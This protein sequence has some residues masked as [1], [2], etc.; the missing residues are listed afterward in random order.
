TVE[1]QQAVEAETKGRP[2]GRIETLDGDVADER[3]KVKLE[4]A[5]P[6]ERPVDEAGRERG[7]ARRERGIGEPMREQDVGKRFRRLDA[8][9]DFECEAAR[10]A[11][12][13]P[14][15]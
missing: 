14:P 8:Q 10:A 4:A 3:A 7:L 2:D 15:A 6:R 9:Q 13:G 5:L 1:K 11:G 12:G